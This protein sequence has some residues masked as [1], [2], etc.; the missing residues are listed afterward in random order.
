VQE[1]L[2]S[3]TRQQI[4]DSYKECAKKQ[5]TEIKRGRPRKN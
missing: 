4:E 5:G 3:A 1:Q 2:T